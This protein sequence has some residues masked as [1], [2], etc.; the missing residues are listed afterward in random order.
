MLRHWP[1]PWRAFA[2]ALDAGRPVCSPVPGFSKRKAETFHGKAAKRSCSI[3]PPALL[4][5][6]AVT[7]TASLMTTAS[8]PPAPSACSTATGWS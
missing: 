3:Y 7:M 6:F 2:V 1:A 8:L 5:M 4:D